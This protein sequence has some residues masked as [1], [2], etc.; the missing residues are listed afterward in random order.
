MNW[1]L[2]KVEKALNMEDIGEETARMVE[3]M[4]I[5][6]IATKHVNLWTRQLEMKRN[7]M[8]ELAGLM[9]V[10]TVKKDVENENSLERWAMRGTH[11]FS[12][13]VKRLL[14]KENENVV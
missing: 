1:L 2:E 14:F 4:A 12:K 5:L 11:F 3:R 9:K 8:S 7:E 13:N 10:Y 6:R